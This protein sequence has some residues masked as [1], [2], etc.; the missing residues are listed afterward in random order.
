MF[1]RRLRAWLKATSNAKVRLSWLQ[2][3]NLYVWGSLKIRGIREVDFQN[4]G[5]HILA[6]VLGYQGPPISINIL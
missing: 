2:L 5:D 6:F 3:G 4:K 1:P